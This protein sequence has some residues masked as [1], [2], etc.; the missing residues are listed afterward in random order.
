[1]AGTGAGAQQRLTYANLG[2]VVQG[3]MDTTFYPYKASVS[4]L[5]FAIY[6]AVWGFMGTGALTTGAAAKS[7]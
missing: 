6:H 5:T 2:D 7:A 3:L 4:G 1:V